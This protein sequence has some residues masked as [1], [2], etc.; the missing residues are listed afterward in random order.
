MSR[1]GKRP[2]AI[3][4][5]VTA[6]IDGGVVS[7]KGPKGTLSMPMADEVTYTLEDGQISIVPAIAGG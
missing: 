5:G 1:T 6:T 3:P 2:V 7:M 4:A